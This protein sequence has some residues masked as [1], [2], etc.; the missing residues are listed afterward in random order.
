MNTGSIRKPVV[1]GLF[2]PGNSDELRS[3]LDRLFA[4]AG[5][6]V[7]KGTVRGIIA[8]HAGYIYSGF[9]AASGYA[10]L[11]GASYDSVVVVSP[12]HKEFFKGVSVYP[13]AAYQT[14]LGTVAIAEN[15]RE[16]L[17]Q[18][19]SVVT[20]SEV[21]HQKEHAIEVHLPFLQRALPAFRLLPL[22]IGDQSRDICFELGRAL[23]K[24]LHGEN[25]LLVASTDLSH[26]YPSRV[27]NRLDAVV[28]GDLQQFDEKCLMDDLDSGKAEACGGGP[29]VAVMTALRALGARTMEVVHHCNSGDVTGDTSSVV[30]Y[31]AAVA[32]A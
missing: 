28:V 16:R 3:D 29:V 11:G 19:S 2:Y 6:P 32:Y 9:T 20:A 10:R 31:V 14:P 15:L 13:G 7:R 27:A 4:Q 30:G 12:S 24:V 17:I 21:G 8:P 1:A 18:E 5:T 22:V 26:Y 25:T 23:G